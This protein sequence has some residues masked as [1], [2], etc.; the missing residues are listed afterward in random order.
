MSHQPLPK[1]LISLIYHVELSKAGWRD[2]LIEQVLLSS[3][4][5]IGNS[6][7]IAN[8]RDHILSNFGISISEGSLSRAIYELTRKGVVIKTPDGLL[9]ITEQTKTSLEKQ[10]SEATAVE[11]QA[12]NDFKLRLSKYD[13][14]FDVERQWSHFLEKCLVPLVSELGVKTYSLLSGQVYDISATSSYQAYLNSHAPEDHSLIS[15]V[16]LEFLS[17]DNTN[18]RSFVVRQ[19][20]AHLLARAGELDDG[21]VQSLASKLAQSVSFTIFLDTNV[22]FSLLNL[23]ENPANAVVT[24]LLHLLDTLASRINVK[25]YILPIT[26]EETKRT[27]VAFRDKVAQIKFTK[28]MG[29]AVATLDG[30]LSG[31]FQKYIQV[32][33]EQPIPVSPSEYFTPY[34][35]NL[36][37]FLRTRKIEL[38]NDNIETLITSQP[39]VDDLLQQEYREKEKPENRQKGYEVLKH[40]VLLWHYT[41]KKRDSVV[42]SPLDAKYWVVTVDNQLLGFDSFKQRSS[43]NVLPVC[44][45]P[46]VLVQMLQLWLPKSPELEK[47]LIHSLR[48]M[49]PQEFDAEAEEAA[50]KILKTLSQYENS[51]NINAEVMTSILMNQALRQRLRS[52]PDV[53]EQIRLVESAII[54]ELEQAQQQ[55]EREKVER[56]KSEQANR[57]L[58]QDILSKEQ[59]LTEATQQAKQKSKEAEQKSKE[60]EDKDNDNLLLQQRISSL[61][62]KSKNRD[63]WTFSLA[64]LVFSSAIG[65]LYRTWIPQIVLRIN[66]NDNWEYPVIT[67]LLVILWGSIWMVLGSS[68][69]NVKE[70]TVFRLFRSFGSW[71]ISIIIAVIVGYFTN[72]LPPLPIKE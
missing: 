31:I 52:D 58:K 19:L 44:I 1:E 50:I 25:L 9:K 21:E 33:S 29:S 4:V 20:Y 64:F 8:L 23:H 40:D 42:E 67:L 41:N 57:D 34:I 14:L 3:C 11:D 12:K 62:I 46:N 38:Y 54:T 30:R 63:R 6:T 26:V 18:S 60:A 55:L 48:S 53:N 70:W 28:A 47:A 66:Y 32:V 68:F 45:H 43:S 5:A 27:L 10:I 65:Y 51:A 49:V 37:A 13:L 35:E 59:L 16:V 39:V 15:K 22:V 72:Q 61:E 7:S 69:S 56:E 24:D 71:I 36:V 2:R 17:S